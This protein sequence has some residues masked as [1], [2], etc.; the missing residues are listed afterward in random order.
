MCFLGCFFFFSSF[1]FGDHPSC[2][3]LPGCALLLWNDWCGHPPLALCKSNK[4]SHPLSP[5][6][7]PF[8][9]GFTNLSGFFSNWLF[10]FQCW[11]L[12]QGSWTCQ[13]SALPLSD[14]ASPLWL[15]PSYYLPTPCSHCIAFPTLSLLFISS[16]LLIMHQ[17][18]SHVHDIYIYIWKYIMHIYTHTMHTH[19]WCINYLLL[20]LL[21]PWLASSHVFALPY[22]SI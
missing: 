12:S 11:G 7:R 18:P 9:N 20:F 8:T 17:F 15:S 2:G 13:A 6:S 21:F 19:K 10:A 16:P 1:I 5:L 22:E 14:T 4:C 3:D